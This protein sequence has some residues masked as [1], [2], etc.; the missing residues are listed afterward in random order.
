MLS[1]NTRH[2][3]PFKYL[4]KSNFQ[5]DYLYSRFEIVDFLTTLDMF[6]N[7]GFKIDT[8]H[9]PSHENDNPIV[10][11]SL[12]MNTRGYSQ[13]DYQS[14]YYYAHS[15]DNNTSPET[16][17]KRVIVITY[18]KGFVR[19]FDSWWCLVISDKSVTM[20]FLDSFLVR[21]YMF[22]ENNDDMLMIDLSL[23]VPRW[24]QSTS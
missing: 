19:I 16:F 8:D 14:E 3:A 4:L 23:A 1:Q 22:H 18:N 12:S 9:Y 20:T 21:S 2:C 17:I 13:I 7:N 11:K 24:V 15:Y 5:D 6:C 10:W